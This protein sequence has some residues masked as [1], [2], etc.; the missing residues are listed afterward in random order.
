VR[1][2]ITFLVALSMSLCIPGRTQEEPAAPE[3]RAEN[4]NG[5]WITQDGVGLQITQSGTQLTSVLMS[6]AAECPNGG[7]RAFFIQG[8][9]SGK[10]IKGR[11]LRCTLPLVLF[12]D[13]GLP[14]IYSAEFD[15]EIMSEEE[16]MLVWIGEHW[17]WDTE[18]GKVT[19]CRKDSEPKTTTFLQRCPDLEALA[20]DIK[21]LLDTRAKAERDL[22]THSKNVLYS[23]KELQQGS[24]REAELAQ[25]LVSQ[26]KLALIGGVLAE[27]SEETAEAFILQVVLPI[28][29]IPALAG[30]VYEVYDTGKD[31]LQWYSQVSGSMTLIQSMADLGENNSGT[32]V[33]QM[34]EFLKKHAPG[35]MPTFEE[36]VKEIRR[37][38]DARSRVDNEWRKSGEAAFTIDFCSKLLEQ[39]RQEYEDLKTKGCHSL[40]PA[41]E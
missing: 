24:E 35:I 14:S 3:P 15:G 2:Q 32:A 33:K 36:L 28:A 9:I 40:G 6:E 27:V 11:M 22:G 41:V 39:K 4:L 19:N 7:T 23:L 31:L 38:A 17:I 8:Q 30:K 18:D 34:A 20:R 13:C 37:I 16:V 29:G 21:F 1:L 26:L 25:S 12:R 5:F 10:H